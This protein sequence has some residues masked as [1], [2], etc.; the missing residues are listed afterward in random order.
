[1]ID[2][3]AICSLNK[4]Y[5]SQIESMLQETKKNNV[6]FVIVVGHHPILALGSSKNCLN[7]KLK[8][9]L[10]YYNVKAYLILHD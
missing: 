8:P 3:T 7:E 10:H 2:T 1:M 4:P 6:T 5:T 9:L